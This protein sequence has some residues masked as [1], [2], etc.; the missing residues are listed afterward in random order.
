MTPLAQWIMRDAL[1]PLK[2]QQL[3]MTP[4]YD[5]DFLKV[6]PQ[7]AMF[8]VSQVI[9]LSNT[10]LRKIIHFEDDLFRGI[11][12]DRLMFLP[13]PHTW[14]EWSYNHPIR[15]GAYL[16]PAQV[17]HTMFQDTAEI[18]T[19]FWL[20][21]RDPAY[22]L[23]VGFLPMHGTVLR[24]PHIEVSRR[25]SFDL[26]HM[27]CGKTDLDRE[28]F[29]EYVSSIVL[30]LYGHLA[31]INTPR[32]IRQRAHAPHKGLQREITRAGGKTRLQDWHEVLLEI[33]A[34]EHEG[35]DGKLEPAGRIVGRKCDHFVRSHVRRIRGGTLE[36]QVRAHR[37]GDP[38]LGTSK[39]R[40]SVE[41]AA[42][43]PESQMPLRAGPTSRHD[44]LEPP[45]GRRAIQGG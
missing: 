4:E 26:R 11:D 36:I 14:I 16:R 41:H 34:P 9:E 3:I 5:I 39:T 31:I 21:E 45:D 19:V 8:E 23:S 1:K 37:R 35:E 20:G 17:T 44:D 22:L 43:R 40:Y 24:R 7:C 13:S 10:V 27:L 28:R 33:D 2:D 12:D 25:A 18:A 30:D 32:L 38:A 6:L 29:L 42:C 15:C